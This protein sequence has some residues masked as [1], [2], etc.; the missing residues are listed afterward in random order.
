MSASSRSGSDSDESIPPA[1]RFLRRADGLGQSPS[2]F[3]ACGNNLNFG[4]G[5]SDDNNINNPKFIR[6]EKDRRRFNI[7][8]KTEHQHCGR[9]GNWTPGWLIYSVKEGN[10]CQEC[11]AAYYGYK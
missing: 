9:C 5:V 11:F 10:V 1:Q 2:N 6:S 8:S 7:S 4:K 3:D